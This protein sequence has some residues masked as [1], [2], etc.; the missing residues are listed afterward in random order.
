VYAETRTAP[1][2]C[3]AADKQ[4]SWASTRLVLLEFST[5]LPEARVLEDR[6][7]ANINR[8]LFE[9]KTEWLAM[10][11]SSS[12]TPRLRACAEAIERGGT[13]GV[14]VARREI[15]KWRSPAS[16]ATR[17]QRECTV[18]AAMARSPV[19]SCHAVSVSHS[20]SSYA[21]RDRGVLA[22]SS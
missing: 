19:P 14:T 18:Y 21:L 3:S 20:R 17:S 22:F 15:T 4:T 12:R 6:Y 9:S 5:Q 1:L 2:I 7:G 8:W 13:R 10:S 16:P 11:A